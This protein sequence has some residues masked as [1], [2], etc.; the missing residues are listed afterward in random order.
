MKLNKKLNSLN[1]Q[2]VFILLKRLLIV[3]LL[4]SISRVL[5]YFYNINHF[6]DITFSRFLRIM[7]GGIRFDIAALFYINSL[8]IL[9]YLLP[10]NFKYKKTYKK[11][12]KYIFLITNGIALAIN[13]MDF[14]Y[15]DFILKRSTADVF[16]FA[17]EGNIFHLFILFFTDYWIGLVIWIS[18]ML[19]LIF[20]YRKTD[21]NK[22]ENIN[23]L[24]YYISGLFWLIFILYFSVI[25]IRGGFTRTT[26]PINLN[27]AGKYTEKPIETA[28]V[29]NTP[30]S[31][32][33]TINKKPLELKNY[34]TEDELEAI[35][36]P[37]HQADTINNFDNKNVVIFIIESMGKEYIGSLNKNID[38][39]NYKGFMPFVDS[40][41]QQS[42]TFAR[43][44]ANGR[45]SIDALPSVTASIPALVNPYVSSKYSTNTINSIASLLKEKG[46]QTA[47]FHGAP[48][49]SM[50][51]ESFVKIAG[52]DKYFGMTEYNNDDD[53]DGS[54]AIWDEEFFQFYANEINK[55]K[56]P[57]HTTLFSAS[58][59]H[60][61]K[62]PE[63]YNGKFK[64][65][66]LPIHI[67]IQY[68]DMALKKFFETASK[69]DWYKNTIFVITAD[70]CS[71]SAIDKYKTEIGSF[72]IPIIIFEPS[73]PN[74]KGL[75][76]TITQQ[77]D[78][79]PTILNMLN[80][81]KD[82]ISF[83]NNMLDTSANHFVVNYINNTYQIA[84]DNFV[85]QYRNDKVI[86][87]YNFEK[88]PLL[89]H[90]LI[91]Q[92]I[93]NVKDMKQLLQAF[94]Q[95]YNY[96]MINNELTIK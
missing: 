96:R 84:Q 31:I 35:Y 53:F 67:P 60:P 64:K 66:T 47:F 41:I 12:L 24:A 92:Q 77:I 8:Y 1:L 27:N 75:D 71:Q 62:V 17:K 5:F 61:F 88:D 7:Q 30:F 70:H 26:R 10:F 9:L 32:I 51:F 40:L 37:I 94:I 36:S 23:K 25:G 44:F 76:S 74:F 63:K 19:I 49:G 86:A 3:I 81:D 82:F 50:G 95:Q 43:A 87:I 52:Y 54:W 68:T 65:G 42:K 78:I 58:S 18:L 4:Y 20:L 45:K 38:N 46:Y 14:F 22:N 2:E 89:K 93:D 80:Y 59:H 34:F 85:L 56:E 90:N 11:I 72:S 16:M 69:M 57:F 28:I 29:L 55:M 15:F 13:T 33:R 6:P 83:G 91:H 21:I 79:M 48:N 73:K 39:G